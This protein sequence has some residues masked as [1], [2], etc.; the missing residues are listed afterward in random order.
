MAIIQTQKCDACFAILN[1]AEETKRDSKK[2][3]RDCIEIKGQVISHDVDSSGYR[4]HTFISPTSESDLAFC[5]VECLAEYIEV[6]KKRWERTA[7]SHVRR[8]RGFTDY[9]NRVIATKPA[10]AP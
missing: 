9:K 5:N 6:Q 10:P 3:L 4:V 8:D 2:I 1:G 7:R